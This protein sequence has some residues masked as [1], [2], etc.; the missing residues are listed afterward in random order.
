MTGVR[1]RTAFAASAVAIAAALGVAVGAGGSAPA[2][3]R[4][5]LA[6][7]VA[8]QPSTTTVV[9]FTE[10]QHIANRYDV[11]EAKQRDLVTR[12]VIADD[13]PGLKRRLGVGVRDIA[14]EAFGQTPTGDA[15]VLRLTGAMPS[16]ERLRKAGYEYQPKAGAWSATRRLRP[17]EVIYAWVVRLPRDGVIVIGSHPGAL[18]AVRDVIAGRAPSLVEDRAV[19]GVAEALAG[20]QTAFIQTSGLGCDATEVAVEP[21]RAR[22]VQAAEARFGQVV[23]HSVLGRGLSDDR[24]DFQ[25]FQVAMA[26]KSA[27]V[28][29][30]QAG[31]REALSHGPFLGRS[32]DIAEVL[33]IR[34]SGSDGRIARLAYDHPAD[35]EYLMTGHGPLMP[36][37]C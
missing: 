10:W 14:W 15:A 31:V 25:R 11:R 37:S 18:A 20:V 2:H 13:A 17:S 36:A 21:E 4:G 33:R 6:A 32:G 5:G 12:S 28:A 29:A 8:T 9:G 1:A 35:S 34:S 16:P 3:G 27:A 23:P 26:F 7:A 24:S 22:Q 19:V 30:E